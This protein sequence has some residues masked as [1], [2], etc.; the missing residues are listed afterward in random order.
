VREAAARRGLALDE[1]RVARHVVTSTDPS[2]APVT[3]TWASFGSGTAAVAAPARTIQPGSSVIPASSASRAA[4]R[5]DRAGSP[6]IAADDPVCTGRPSISTS[7]PTFDTSR[8]GCQAPIPNR[9]ADALSAM[10]SGRSE[11]R[12]VGKEW[13]SWGWQSPYSETLV[14]TVNRLNQSEK[15]LMT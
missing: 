14:E 13:K 15:S 12:R 9:A 8:G 6:R 5:S 3:R 10:T 4:A 1:D 7:R 2:P 11:E